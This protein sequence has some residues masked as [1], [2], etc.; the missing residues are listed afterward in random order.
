MNTTIVDP[1]VFDVLRMPDHSN[2]PKYQR[3]A[4]V[5]VE[6]IRRGI[7]R[8]GDRLPAE[9]DLAELT[10]FSLGTVQR[11]LRDLS[12]QGLVVRQ[13]GLGSFVA[14]APRELQDPWHCRFLADD[15]E[16]VLPIY[17]RAIHRET[18]TGIGAWTRYLGAGTDVMRLDR[19]I[20][21]N[22]EFNVFS[23][24]YADRDLLQKLWEMP[25]EEL[26]GVNFK[27]VIIK[28]WRLPITQIVHI[29]RLAEFDVEA[30]ERVGAPIGSSGMFMQA[31][32]RAG[33]DRCTYYQE[34]FIGPTKRALT[35]PE[36]NLSGD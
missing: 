3:L 7:W 25:L 8:P 14:H 36:A 15:G 26:N 18:V 16:T 10:P 30:C 21:V 35:F 1:D 32:A 27:N 6:A 31:V 19:V 20:N 24:F 28:L 22:D 5:L 23:R 34:F 2:R 29:V 17:S 4:D 9:E 12:E 13:H 11:A 33:R